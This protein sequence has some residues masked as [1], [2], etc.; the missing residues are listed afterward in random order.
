MSTRSV[1]RVLLLAAT[2]ALFAAVAAIGSSVGAAAANPTG[3]CLLGIICAPTTTAP[4][5][6]TTTPPA[7]APP[8]SPTTA[9]ATAT[10]AARS[11]ATTRAPTRNVQPSVGVS[12]LP[13]SGSVNL[14]AIGTASDPVAPQL[15]G[16]PDGPSTSS[17]TL[18]TEA[19]P[20][21]FHSIAAPAGLPNDHRT[22]RIVLSVM[23]LLVAALALGQLPGSRRRPRSSNG[24]K[25]GKRHVFSRS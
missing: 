21:A 19:L 4:H 5:P 16:T 3:G 7:T 2:S 9:R 20:P 14:P 1:R 18:L 25:A 11:T 24:A 15:A 8:P 10:T 13:V 12:G 6:A 23:A 22:L 17:T